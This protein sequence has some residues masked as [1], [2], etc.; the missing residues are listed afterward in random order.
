MILQFFRVSVILALAFSAQIWALSGTKGTPIGGMGTGYVKFDATNGD[1]AASGKMP[2]FA[3][4]GMS[5]FSNNMSTSSGFHFYAGGEVKKKAATNDEDAKCPLYTAKFGKTGNVNFTLNAFGPII[6]GDGD[7][8]FKLITS[9]LAYFEIT[10]KNEGSEEIEVAVAMEFANSSGDKDLLGGA[11][12][13]KA[14]GEKAIS[15]AGD[16]SAGNSYLIAGCSNGEATYSAGSY[17]SFGSNGTLENG[18]GNLVAAKCKIAA[19][20]EARFKF[21]LSWWRTHISKVDRFGSGKVDAD[22]YYYHNNYNN[23]KSAAEFGVEH[24]DDASAAVKSMVSRVMA[25]NFPDWYKDR[26]LNNLYPLIHNSVCAK[27]GRMAYWEGHYPIIGTIDQAEHAA[28]F[29]TANWPKNQ[30]QELQYWLRTAHTGEGEDASLKGQIHHDFNMGPQIWNDE[31]HFM[32]PWD[33]YKHED[34]WWCP[35]STTW[36]DL[37]TMAIFKLY[38]L[39]MATGSRDSVQIYYP[40]ILK[41]AER[42][43]RQ[44]EEAGKKLP[45]KSK[46]TYDSENNETP[47]YASG[48]AL[49]AFLAMEQM[50][51]YVGDDQNA[52]KYREWYTAARAEYK[53]EQFNSDFATGRDYCEGDVAGYSWAHY[54]GLEPIMD[55]DFINTSCERLSDYYNSKDDLRDKLGWW[56]FYTYDHWGGAEIARGKPDLAMKVH[57]WDYDYYYTASPAYVFWQDLQKTN[58]AYASYMTGPCVWRSFYQ[59]TGYLLDNANKR[60][61]IRPSIPTDMNNK[62]ENAALM[63]P[64]GWGTLNYDGN[65]DGDRKQLIKVTFDS[66]VKVKQIVL[67]NNTEFNT[68]EKPPVVEIAGFESNQFNVYAENSGMEKN[69]RIVFNDEIEI[70][71]SGIEIKVMNALLGVAGRLG[72]AKN[73]ALSFAENRISAGHKISYSVNVNGLV[74]MDLLS[75]N[76]KK[77]GSIMSG[78]VNAGQHSFVWNGKTIDGKAINS[79]MM[80]LRLKSSSGTISKKVLTGF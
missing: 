68:P 56:H 40:K 50:A 14:D 5:E 20:Q 65:A 36:S 22:N 6:P 61:W 77:I 74:S 8:N 4:E 67:N 12:S 27:D 73:S 75:L 63:N 25:S 55:E 30:W 9:P 47:Q 44:C 15:F 39:M 19:G 79:S 71:S 34:Y 16:E 11:R 58:K 46:S 52:E 64:Y 23:S 54:F 26:L 10:A 53:K 60:L 49:A 13:G 35:N 66:P 32:C 76:G 70:S 18:D 33:N 1:F 45:I 42:L 17:G 72:I 51:K 62:I 43:L 57:K 2:P 59:M 38:E 80:I 48:V 29:Y 7:E 21:T 24:F 41:T 28:L 31:A 37:N 69:I 78:A 3:S